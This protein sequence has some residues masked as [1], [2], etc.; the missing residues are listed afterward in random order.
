ML[1]WSSILHSFFGIIIIITFL[2]ICLSLPALIRAICFSL[3]FILVFWAG[4]KRWLHGR[5]NFHL[6][7]QSVNKSVGLILWSLGLF[8]SI[9][10]NKVKHNSSPQVKLR[11]LC[12]AKTLLIDSTRWIICTLC[13]HNSQFSST[14]YCCAVH[15]STA[16]HFLPFEILQNIFND[17]SFLYKMHE[18]VFRKTSGISFFNML[19]K[20]YVL[21]IIRLKIFWICLS[22]SEGIPVTWYR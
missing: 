11:A 19:Q 3:C 8:L 5:E 12:S 14:D 1:S 20:L 22:S 16:F 10:Q 13:N 7:V 6:N 4:N 15:T 2:G 18:H 21:H 17:V 9:K